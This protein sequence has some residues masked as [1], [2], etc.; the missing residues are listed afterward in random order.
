MNAE[1]ARKR[2]E[3]AK[4][5]CALSTSLSEIFKAIAAAASEGHDGVALS[6]SDFKGDLSGPQWD[7]LERVLR[8]QG[9]KVETKSD[10]DQRTGES[11]TTTRISWGR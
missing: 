7:A 5:T 9:Y 4:S 1:E 10:G 6:T 11:W 8:D 3:A 2:T